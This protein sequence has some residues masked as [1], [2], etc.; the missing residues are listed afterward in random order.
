MQGERRTPHQFTGKILV[1]GATGNVGRLVVDHLLAAGATNVRAL[2]NHPRRAAL[3]T[4]VEIVEGYLGRLETMP[5][6]LDGVERMYLAPL[7]RTV[8]DVLALARAAGVRH[9]VDLS[10][11]EADVEAAGDPSGWHYHAVE[12]AVTDSGIPWT[13]LRPGEFMNNYLIWA[14]EIKETGVVRGGY[15]NSANAPIDLDDIA[16]V[17]ARVLLEDGHTGKTYLMTGPQ[18]LSRA[19]M[20]R[21]IG[22]AIGRDVRYEELPH[23]EA[24][25]ALRPAMGEWA[26]W[27]LDGMRALAENPQRA[28]TTIADLTGRPATTFAEWAARN[29]SAFA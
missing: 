24:L 5:A 10:S 9:I 29:A 2:T 17:A 23:E 7:P 20:A 27:Y 16:A 21:Q 14:D 19:E 1:T 22:V 3:P 8:H 18:S 15:A 6:A 25:A 12:K 11:S 13:H 4:G 26:D 28:E